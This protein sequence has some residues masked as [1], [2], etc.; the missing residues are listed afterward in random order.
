[1]LARI[2]DVLGRKF[3]IHHTT[4]QFEHVGCAVAESGCVIPAEE[5]HHHEH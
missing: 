3:H 4:V 5:H 2:N 1:V